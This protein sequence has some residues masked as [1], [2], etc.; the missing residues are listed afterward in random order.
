MLTDVDMIFLSYFSSKYQIEG[1]DFTS[2]LRDNLFI[3]VKLQLA[4]I[5]KI[6]S[7]LVFQIQLG[8][9]STLQ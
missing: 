8:K 2:S 3:K 5:K 9:E 4:L 7:L 6:L 1:A